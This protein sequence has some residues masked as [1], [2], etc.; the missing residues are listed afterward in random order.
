MTAAA[1]EIKT[2]PI[3]TLSDMCAIPADRRHAFLAD[4]LTW[5]VWREEVHTQL[6]IIYDGVTCGK[7][8]VSG[9]F[10]WVDDGIEGIAG[11][12]LTITK[13]PKT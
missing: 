1:D 3:E 13:E 5:M 12:N 11:I 10:M 7:P 2:Y 8:S 6:N 4:L 9:S